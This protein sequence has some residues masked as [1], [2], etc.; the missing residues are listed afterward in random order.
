LSIGRAVAGFSGLIALSISSAAAA[1]PELR[2]GARA[3]V[4]GLGSEGRLWSRTRPC[5]A[6]TGD[7]LFGRARNGDFGIG[8]FVEVSTAGFW[9]ARIGGGASLL[10]PVHDDAPL[11]ASAG[12]FS[13]ALRSTAVGGTLFW[14]A[15]S[16]NFHGVY[17]L[18]LGLFAGA[19]LDLGDRRDTLVLVGAD[20]DAFFL[21]APF[22]LLADAVR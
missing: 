17:G 10:V 6:L 8:P 22:L 5:F 1:H 7:L 21:V 20:V 18:A 12:V 15:R 14:G 9:D 4:C 3:S 16:H 11:V 2:T 13:H 19:T